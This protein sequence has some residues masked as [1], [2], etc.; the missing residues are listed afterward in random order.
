MMR[1]VVVGGRRPVW[2]LVAAVVVFSGALTG[3]AQASPAG[4]VDLGT[5]PGDDDSMVLAVNDAGVMVGR[6]RKPVARIS[7]RQV[8]VEGCTGSTSL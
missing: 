4:P 2:L 3:T 1:N 8:L 5:L 6:V 7:A